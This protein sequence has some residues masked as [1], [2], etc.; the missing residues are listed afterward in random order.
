MKHEQL[1]LPF[2]VGEVKVTARPSKD[3]DKSVE[4]FVVGCQHRL[5]VPTR[6]FSGDVCPDHGIRC[7][8]SSNSPTYSYLQPRRNI[9]HGGPI[10][11]VIDIVGNPRSAVAD[12]HESPLGHD[13]SP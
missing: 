4:C 5:R 11:E 8:H 10:A 6:T 12:D 7:H 2:G 1:G 13:V 9:V 3:G